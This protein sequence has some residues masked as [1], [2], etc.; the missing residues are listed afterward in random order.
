MASNP[1][2]LAEILSNWLPESDIGVMKH[3]FADHGRDYVFIVEDCVGGSPGTHEL[4][5]THVV[6]VQYE[7]RVRDDV[8]PKSWTDEFID[9]QA[10]LRAGE[11][12]GYVWG[13]NWSTA[14]PGIAAPAST[15]EAEKWTKRLGRQMHAMSIETD[16]FLISM[17]FHD[18]RVR[19]LSDD[20]PTARQTIVPLP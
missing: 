15:G 5:F 18:V 9:Y 20:A 11:P 1:N 4:V 17:I 7:T 14:Y 19:K 6:N 16:R 3:G 13:T 8:W 2:P 10:W 12:D